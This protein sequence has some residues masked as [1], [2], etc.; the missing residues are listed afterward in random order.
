MAR[1]VME[2]VGEAPCQCFTPGGVQITSPERIS[3]TAPPH[4]CTRPTPPVTMSNCPLGCV[5]HAERAPA[6]NDTDAHDAPMPSVASKRGVTCTV[7]VKVSE[8][9]CRV[10]REPLRVMIIVCAFIG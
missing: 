6:S 8:G 4:C 9:P 5:C 2:V 1:C 7:P 3:S 10:G